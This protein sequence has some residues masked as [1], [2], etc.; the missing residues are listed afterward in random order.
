M[1]LNFVKRLALIRFNFAFAKVNQ[2]VVKDVVRVLRIGSQI[3]LY[4]SF[5]VFVIVAYSLFRF[6][7]RKHIQFGLLSI[8]NGDLV[9]EAR[10]ICFEI[11]NIDTRHDKAC[12]NKRT[13]QRPNRIK[14]LSKIETKRRCLFRTHRQD[15]RVRS[16]F[17]KCQAK[18]QNVD[19]KD[20]QPKVHT[21]GSWNRKHCSSRKQYQPHHDTGLVGELANKQCGGNRH[22]RIAAVKCRLH[23][24]RLSIANREHVFEHFH[25]WVG[26]VVRKSPQCKQRRNQNEGHEILRWNN[27]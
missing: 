4:V 3:T 20:E 1:L 10:N 27:S 21:A 14:R 13:R 5:D 19:A 16:C 12:G 9:L 22:R 7:E 2:C 8:L 24:R 17:Q 6:Q 25:H 18:R 26:K 11:R 15:E 23:K